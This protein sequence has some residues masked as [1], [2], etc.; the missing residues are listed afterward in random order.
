M[1]NNIQEFEKLFQQFA[2]KGL[3]GL[4]QWN[5]AEYK[6][7]SD[8][9][10]FLYTVLKANEVQIEKE[11]EK[12]YVTDDYENCVRAFAVEAFRILLKSNEIFFKE[13]RDTAIK[14]LSQRHIAWAVY[15]I[16]ETEKK[17]LDENWSIN[18][19]WQFI[20][21]GLVEF[22]AKFYGKFQDNEEAIVLLCKY[23]PKDMDLEKYYEKIAEALYSHISNAGTP[24]DFGY[25]YNGIN[26]IASYIRN[27][28]E[29]LVETLLKQYR[30]FLILNNEIYRHQIATVIM[31]AALTEKKQSE[32]KFFYLDSLMIANLINYKLLQ[33]GEGR[34]EYNTLDLA[35]EEKKIKVFKEPEAYWTNDV[36]D[37]RSFFQDNQLRFQIVLESG[38]IQI[39]SKNKLFMK[40]AFQKNDWR[41]QKYKE[42]EIGAS[43]EKMVKGVPE[44]T[45]FGKL[46]Y[47][48]MLFSL[49]YLENY[50][51]IT[52]QIFDLDHLFTLQL[53]E[54]QL[55]DTKKNENVFPHFYGEE[56]YSLSCIVGKNGTG[57]TSI[58]DFLR[59]TFFKLIKIIDE[60]SIACTEGYVEEDDYEKYEILDTGTRFFVI[61]NFGEKHY[62][63]SNTKEIKICT[64]EVEPYQKRV[65]GSENDMC[66]VAYFSQQIR[67]NEAI[68]SDKGE[69]TKKSVIEIQIS[70]ALNGF[71]QC[72]FSE[73]SSLI[74]KRKIALSIENQKERN[75]IFDEKVTNKE[76]CYQMVLFYSIP[77]SEIEAYLDISSDKKI[78]IYN[79]SNGEQLE[80]IELK[81]MY[82]DQENLKRI[83]EKYAGKPEVALR[84]LSSGQYSKLVF[85]ARLY[86]FIAGYRKVGRQINEYLKEDFFTG[87]EALL[88]GEAALIFID[89]GELYYHPEW[90]REYLMTLLQMIQKNEQDSLVQV[91]LTTNSPF[92]ISDV[93]REDVK[94]IDDGQNIGDETFGQN[95]HMLLTK[96]FFMN[97]TIGEYSRQLINDI[98]CFLSNKEKE[99]SGKNSKLLEYLNE[100][101][102]AYEVLNF[103][104][105]KIGEPIYR[106][107]LKKLLDEWQE[108]R[109]STK[110][111]KIQELERQRQMI[112]EQ[113]KR[114]RGEE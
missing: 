82:A 1:I 41:L 45:S 56:I 100:T 39:K 85:L 110:E 40:F 34:Q 67:T 106:I 91:I 3:Q 98:S 66:K 99:K 73:A 17:K 77:T 28:P 53:G 63:L 9:L 38:N 87:D 71:R 13:D 69:Y 36:L 15:H 54:K 27:L 4:E 86:W 18:E 65:W 96:N 21:L 25:A 37:H 81:E 60:S 79:A 24:Q 89:E 43:I 10:R 19:T 92:I 16:Q 93:L 20:Y 11:H 46:K 107:R 7:K 111:W 2:D 33:N 101:D 62:F 83:L 103:L 48:P 8:I 22:Y 44:D 35:L 80:D 59:E 52:Q 14:L 23:Y 68:W 78:Y 88:E 104:I 31:N 50:R 109:Q 90:Q 108:A 57:K 114:I 42:R 95:I 97:Y 12:N 84:Y 74:E 61:F 94:Y 47:R 5:A 105:G 58:I 76:L 32:L 102:D 75:L 112:D 55:K 51:G 30:L 6:T 29:G 72:D 113:I 64:G 70:K 49:L 26:L